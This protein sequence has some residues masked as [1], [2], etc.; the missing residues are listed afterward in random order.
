MPSRRRA[1][2]G[3]RWACASASSTPSCSRPR[4]CRASREL[5]ITASVQF[6][7]APSDRDLADRI[8][9]GTTSLPYAYPRAARLRRDARQRLGR[10]DRGARSA[11]GLARRRAPDAGRAR[12]V[13]PGAGRHRRGGA[14]GEH[15]RARVARAATSAAA[16]SSSPGTSPTSSCSTATRSPA[17]RKS[18]PRRASWRR[19]SAARGR[20]THRPGELSVKSANRRPSRASESG[21]GAKAATRPSPPSPVWSLRSVDGGSVPAGPPP[22]LS[23]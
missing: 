9:G 1:T 2:R 6:S 18:S 10:A 17:S 12:R 21:Q 15:R 22:P 14:C 4:T 3:S 8:W 20:T 19:C 5:G 11:R 16:E 13:A 7:H 23:K